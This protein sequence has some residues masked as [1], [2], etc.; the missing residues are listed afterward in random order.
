LDAYS[1]DVWKPV[2]VAISRADRRR[3]RSVRA[4]AEFGPDAEAVLD[5]LE[6]TEFA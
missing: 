3:E 1:G 4:K 5:V 6:L 2:Y